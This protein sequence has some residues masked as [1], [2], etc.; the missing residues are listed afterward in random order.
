MEHCQ[1]ASFLLRSMLEK[2]ASFYQTRKQQRKSG[3][4]LTFRNNNWDRVDD[5]LYI[6][7]QINGFRPRTF[8]RGTKV[9]NKSMSRTILHLDLDAFFCAVEEL[10]RP[11]PAW[12]SLC[13]GGQPA[14]TR[15]SGFLFVCRTPIR[16]PLGDADEPGA[17]ALS[18]LAGHLAPPWK[19]RG[20]VREGHGALERPCPPWSSKSRSMKPSWISATCTSPR[21]RSPAGFK[22]VLMMNSGC[23]ARWEWHPT[24]WLPRSPQKWGKRPPK[25]N[26]HPT[27]LRSSRREPNRP[28]WNL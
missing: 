7:H 15:G 21:N 17:A 11:I 5:P 18:G 3:N 25:R 23:P 20:N 1:F 4:E 8:R 12:Q 14:G 22:N 2:V 13:R 16:G 28:S 19:L 6:R 26:F 9:Y 10:Q 24:S 27:P